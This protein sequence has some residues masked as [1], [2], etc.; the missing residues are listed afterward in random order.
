M[1]THSC[2][3]NWKVKNLCLVVTSTWINDE[4]WYELTKQGDIL[5]STAT[6]TSCLNWWATVWT[7]RWSATR[8]AAKAMEMQNWYH[9]PYQSITWRW[10]MLTHDEELFDGGYVVCG[11]TGSG[12]MFS[13]AALGASVP[14]LLQERWKSW[15]S[16]RELPRAPDS[17]STREAEE[18]QELDAGHGAFVKKNGEC[19]IERIMEWRRFSPSLSASTSVRGST[20]ISIRSVSSWRVFDPAYPG[21][22]GLDRPHRVQLYPEHRRGGLL[23]HVLSGFKKY[24]IETKTRADCQPRPCSIKRRIIRNPWRLFVRCRKKISMEGY[25]TPYLHHRGQIVVTTWRAMC[26]ATWGSIERMW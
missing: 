16:Q 25:Q 12:E 6:P 17:P 21:S 8:A 24:L 9:Q 4:P 3:N 18:V 14:R 5:A 1:A 19:S 23:W 7:E 26:N 13:R 15:S 11:I 20:R 10:A 22:C 2:R